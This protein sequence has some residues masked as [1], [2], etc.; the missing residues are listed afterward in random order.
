MDEY[1]E[2]FDMEKYHAWFMQLSIRAHG[3]FCHDDVINAIRTKNKINKL[4]KR[5]MNVE[6]TE[7]SLGLMDELFKLEYDLSMLVISELKNQLNQS[8]DHD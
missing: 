8:M 6:R 3:C 7:D 5:L 1:Y 4:I 2:Q